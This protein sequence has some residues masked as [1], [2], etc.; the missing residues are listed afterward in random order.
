MLAAI[1]VLNA[2]L[3][4][5]GKVD[6]K[7]TQLHAIASLKV[8]LDAT[9]PQ[10]GAATSSAANHVSAAS[11]VTTALTAQRETMLAPSNIPDMP[12]GIAS[13][14][15]DVN[16]EAVSFSS[17]TNI[18]YLPKLSRRTKLLNNDPPYIDRTMMTM[19]PAINSRYFNTLRLIS[20]EWTAD[21]ASKHFGRSVWVQFVFCFDSLYE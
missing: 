16:L 4:F 2:S 7:A 11:A 8:L 12:N 19:R 3:Y 9:K 10:N 21:K 1:F 5:V 20:V 15:N 14:L 18:A 13:N 6:E 17:K